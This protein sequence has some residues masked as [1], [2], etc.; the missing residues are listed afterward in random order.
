MRE[1]HK[2]RIDYLD[3]KEQATSRTVWPLSLAFFPP[4]W[5]AVSWCELRSDFRSFRVDRIGAMTVLP[6]RY[7]QQ[8]GRRLVDYLRRHEPG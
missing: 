4:I 5:L 6:D 7:P 8:P 3:L 2:V 1:Q